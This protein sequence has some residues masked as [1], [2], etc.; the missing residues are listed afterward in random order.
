MANQQRDPAKE[1]CG[2]WAERAGS[3]ASVSSS[4]NPRSTPG[5]GRL[6]SGMVQATPSPRSCRPW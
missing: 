5:G 6:V 3:S 4:P 1:V 2:K